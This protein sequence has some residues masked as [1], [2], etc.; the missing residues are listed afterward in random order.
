METLEIAER[1]QEVPLFS[2]L[3]TT[4]LEHVAA[5]THVATFPRRSHLFNA[6][7]PGREF[8]VIL[9]GEAIVRAIGP[10]GRLR[11]V[12]YLREG[13]SVGVTSLLLGEPHDATVEAVTPVT[14]LVLEGGDFMRLRHE[15]PTLE[16]ELTLPPEVIAKLRRGRLPWLA[17]G[18][19]LIYFSRRHWIVL[20]RSLLLPL[21]LLGL[22]SVAMF[23]I[24][25]LLHWSGFVAAGLL[26]LLLLGIVAWYVVDW[27][28]DYLAVTTQRVLRRELILFTYESRHEAPLDRV[29]D[30]AV[31]YDRLGRILGYGHLSVQTAAKSGLGS[32]VFSHL[33]EPNEAA[34][35]VFQQVYRAQAQSMTTADEGIRQELK[36]QLGWIA[37]EELATRGQERT[38]G[39]G[40][41]QVA[42]PRPVGRR[43]WYMLPPLRLQE[44]S[45]ITWR[46]HWFFLLRRTLVP[47]LALLAWTVVVVVAF[48][49]SSALLAGVSL[50]LVLGLLVAG[51]AI[52]FWLWWE[53]VD[54]ENDVYILTD[55][56]II[57]IEKRPFFGAEDRREATLD[58][59]QNV[60]LVVPGRLATLLQ[61]GNV[62]I[63]TAGGEGRF[64]FSGVMA[65]HQVQRDIMG[66]VAQYR[67]QRQQI[68]S[69]QRQAEIAKWFAVYEGL[70]G[71]RA[72]EPPVAGP[73]PAESPGP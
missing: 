36:R 34:A 24:F 48:W 49:G 66:R 5:I 10:H 62:D 67:E 30:V 65:P 57:D 4:N 29:Q 73:A 42:P 46:K 3:S 1:L 20:L 68:E 52:A 13:D 21:L 14:A 16:G 17:P 26:L 43:R 58:R 23:S 37:R 22:L 71:Q 63:D 33:P 12:A 35:A 64:T 60:N 45:R 56:R 39:I 6:G 15:L 70:R 59:I 69:R 32:L 47:A 50:G 27:R 38:A 11:P 51:L 9:S 28:N 25:G 18:E 2:R 72:P 55:D 8:V 41:V 40:R 54:W 31:R 7:Q 44:D 53:I 19:V 61:Y